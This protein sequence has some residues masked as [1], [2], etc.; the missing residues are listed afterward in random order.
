MP[1]LIATPA[2]DHPPV[3]RGQATLA[4]VDLGRMTSI[5]P[6]AGQEGAVQAALSGLGLDFPAPNRMHEGQ[7]ARIIWTGRAQAFL[8]GPAAPDLGGL[9]ATTDQTDGWVALSLS[10]PSAADVLMRLVPLDLRAFAPGDAARSGLNHMPL[11]LWRDA[12]GF[13]I[14]TFRSMARTAWHEIET[15]MEMLEARA[16]VAGRA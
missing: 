14:L 6:F 10:G 5:A 8:I 13:T 11:I 7:G 16:R 2:L 3:T 9:A 1:D 15:A 12:A 4:V